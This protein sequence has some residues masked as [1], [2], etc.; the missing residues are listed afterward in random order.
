[1]VKFMITFSTPANIGVFEKAYN[2]LLALV[3]RMPEHL[4]GGKGK[5][6]AAK[7]Y[8]EAI[9]RGPM[10]RGSVTTRTNAAVSSSQVSAAKIDPGVIHVQRASSR[11][12]AKRYSV[13]AIA[14]ATSVS[15]K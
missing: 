10:S 13:A 9:H 7:S 15:S 8:R 3:E 4:R 14:A 2:D 1:M 12:G 6:K 5:A 11:D